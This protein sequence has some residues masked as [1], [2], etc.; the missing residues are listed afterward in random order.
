MADVRTNEDLLAELAAALERVRDRAFGYA[1]AGD[2]GITA[3]DD[4]LA[5]VVKAHRLVNNVVH[6]G[7]SSLRHLQY[8]L[9][10][11]AADV[12]HGRSVGERDD[13]A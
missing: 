9:E 4:G 11:D 1:T 10:D 5:F 8:Q 2:E 6:V 13:D 12:I 7:P 3:L